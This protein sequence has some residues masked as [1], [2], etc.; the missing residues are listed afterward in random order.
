MSEHEFF[1]CPY[2]GNVKTFKV[3]TSSYQIVV[4]SPESGTR[5]DESSV[6]PS[7]RPS[8]NAIECQVCLKKMEF[9]VACHF[10]KMYREVTEK[11]QEIPQASTTAHI[12]V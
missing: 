5:I 4:Q 8:D 6:L 2:C 11:Y 9:D 12:P 3:F 1:I 10:S 7:L